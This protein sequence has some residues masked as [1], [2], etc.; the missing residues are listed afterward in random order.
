ME[1]DKTRAKLIAYEV[2]KM[3]GDGKNDDAI[4]YDNAAPRDP[5]TLQDPYAD[6]ATEIW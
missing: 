5:H 3:F 1:R 4:G 2:S 6:A